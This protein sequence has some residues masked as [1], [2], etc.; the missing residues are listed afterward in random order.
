VS[1]RRAFK[2]LTL[3]AW[4]A[5]WLADARFASQHISD[6]GELLESR[7]PI[8][9]GESSWVRGRERSHD[10]ATTI[11]GREFG[12]VSAASYGSPSFVVTIVV[13]LY[14]IIITHTYLVVFV[15]SCIHIDVGAI[16]E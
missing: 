3:T 13:P 11:A 10:V 1:C 5:Y 7:R 15:T 6:C 8:P 2:A 12:V 4:Y 16:T 9:T 14:Y